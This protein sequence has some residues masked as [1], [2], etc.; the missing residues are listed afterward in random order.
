[1][2]VFVLDTN[3]I[4]DIVA[5]TPNATVLARLAANR[6]HTLCLCE[7]VDYEIRRGYLKR[8][9]TTRLKIYESRIRPQFQWVAITSADW[10]KAAQFWAHTVGHGRQLADIDLLV[11]AVATR[12]KAIIVSADD[13]FDAL[14][15]GRENWRF[16]M[17]Q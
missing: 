5:P 10:Q 11:A 7:P 13:D 6:T 17:D 16:M 1:M 2:T 8:N 15:I 12:L 4:S 9:A 14:S 3:V